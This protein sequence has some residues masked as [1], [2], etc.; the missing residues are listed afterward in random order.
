MYV[1]TWFL[2][3]DDPRHRTQEL[4]VRTIAYIH[5]DGDPQIT[6]NKLPGVAI[7]KPATLVLNN[8]NTSYN[9][10]YGFRIIASG[11]PNRIFY[12]AVFIAGK[13]I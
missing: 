9:A 11:E 10:S 6:Y 5:D 13:H 12:V 7:E 1:R 2:K 3:S 8:V 4:P